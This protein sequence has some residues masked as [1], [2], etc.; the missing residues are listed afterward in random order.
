MDNGCRLAWMID[1]GNEQVF[2]YRADGSITVVNSFSQ[3]LSGEEVL[4]GF[5]ME[6]THKS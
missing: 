5:E 6:F 3:K 1:L 2:I 4:V